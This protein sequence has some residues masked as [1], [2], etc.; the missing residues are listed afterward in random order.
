MVSLDPRVFDSRTTWLL[1]TESKRVLSYTSCPPQRVASLPGFP[2]RTRCRRWARNGSPCFAPHPFSI[3]QITEPLFS[4]PLC[5]NVRLPL[6]WPSKVSL[7]GFGYPHSD[8]SS[9]D[10][11]KSLSTSNALGIRPSEP[12]SESVIE[13]HFRAFLPLLRF[14]AKPHRPDRGAPAISAHSLSRTHLHPRSIR[15]AVGAN[16][17]PGPCS[18]PGIPSLSHWKTAFFFQPL[19]VLFCLISFDM[20]QRNSEVLLLAL[21]HLPLFKGR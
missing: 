10:P 7:T 5:G 16:C 1:S 21:G 8:V 14:S 15:N 4:L 2:F 18:L 12:L 3:F 6:P 13:K 11:R 9:H 17:S 19:H 20:R